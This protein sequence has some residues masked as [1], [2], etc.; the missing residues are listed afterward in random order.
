MFT[1]SSYLGTT[2]THLLKSNIDADERPRA[3]V[4]KSCGLARGNLQP[5][6]NTSVGIT[7]TQCEDANERNHDNHSH[8]KE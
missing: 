1:Q 3:E 5:V 7:H 2:I 8:S 6:Y 4:K